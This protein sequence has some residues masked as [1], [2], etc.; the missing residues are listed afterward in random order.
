MLISRSHTALPSRYDKI[1][2]WFSNNRQKDAAE[3]RVSNPHSQAKY[4]LAATLVPITCEGRELR[5]R[6]S[7]MAACPEADWTDDF[8]YEV[9]LIHDFRLLVRERNES[10]RLDA[11]SVMLDMKT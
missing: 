4:D 8:F 7:A 10:L 3:F 5:M 6:P 9:V 1:K 11:A 2:N